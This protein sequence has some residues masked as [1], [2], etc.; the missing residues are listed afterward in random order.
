MSDTFSQTGIP[1]GSFPPSGSPAP[2]AGRP[3]GLFL[4]VYQTFISP[5]EAFSGGFGVWQWVIALV[6][7]GLLGIATQS[8]QGPY[9]APDIKRAA[10]SQ[11]EQARN[12]LSAQQYEDIRRQIEEGVDQEFKI[13]P[14]NSLTELAFAGLFV[15]C[16]ALFAWFGGNFLLGGQ[17]LFWQVLTVVAFAGF[18]GLAGDVA[19]TAL[20]T[21]KDSS[22][23]HIGL[24]SL[25]TTPDNSFIY[26]LLRQMEFFSMWRIAVT[27]IGLGAIYSKPALKFAF[28][29][30]PLW[31]VFIALVA[32]ANG[33]M[34][35][36][37]VY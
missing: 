1:G 14:L 27:C 21:A 35:G 7:T 3:T 10:L 32:L 29:L 20:M 22:Y 11:L 16:I 13:T 33:L 17:A 5:H 30:T 4:R 15:L 36:A 19:R 2:V 24:G 12:Q 25:W 18:I 31:L 28:I 8:L 34:G 6:I 23:V 37:L 9:L 26:Y